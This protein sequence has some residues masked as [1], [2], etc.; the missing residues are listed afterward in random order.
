MGVLAGDGLAL[1]SDD[2]SGN[3]IAN[4]GVLEHA[5]GG[6]SQ[7]VEA[8]FAYFPFC[9]PPLACGVVSSGFGKPG[10]NHDL[11]ELCAGGA[12]GFVAN[13]P[14]IDVGEQRRSGVVAGWEFVEILFQA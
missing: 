6:M 3:G 8:E 12:R 14:G 9:S 10:F 1:M 5:R 13:T 4:P 11:S 2:V 7:A